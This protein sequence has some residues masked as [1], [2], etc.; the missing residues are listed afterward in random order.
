MRCRARADVFITHQMCWEFVANYFC[1]IKKTTIFNKIQY[2]EKIPS[3]KKP[4]PEDSVLQNPL[5]GKGINMIISSE[6]WLGVQFM[7]VGS[8]D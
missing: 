8:Q 5:K 7:L 6:N 2:F 4:S 1:V 3:I